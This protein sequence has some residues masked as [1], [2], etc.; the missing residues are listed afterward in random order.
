M[1]HLESVNNK[2]LEMKQKNSRFEELRKK[3]VT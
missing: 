1:R 2:E 3:E